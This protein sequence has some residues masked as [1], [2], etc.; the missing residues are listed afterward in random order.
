MDAVDPLGVMDLRPILVCGRSVQLLDG[1][2]AG[3]FGQLL[4][5]DGAGRAKVLLQIL[6]AERE[7]AVSSAILAPTVDGA[8]GR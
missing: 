3:Q 4:H 5:L 6:G 8:R 1:P 7:I 2:F